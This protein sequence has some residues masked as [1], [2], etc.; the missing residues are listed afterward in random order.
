M[1][2]EYLTPQGLK[3]LEEEL[4]HL[5]NVVRLEV[6]RRL[7]EA[8]EDGEIEENAEYEA[9]K[10]QQS[11]VEARIAEIESILANA[12][13]IENTGPTDEVRLG[14]RVTI[15]DVESGQREKYVLVGSTEADPANG[16]ISN[17]SPLGRALIGH[18]TNDI[19]V[20]HAPDGDIKYKIVRIEERN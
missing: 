16:Y 12:V 8:M 6:A 10:Q 7:R 9:A 5:K 15:A 18:K 1:E 19:V 13:I 20:V 14:V 4:D 2:K 11:M 17:E 3:K